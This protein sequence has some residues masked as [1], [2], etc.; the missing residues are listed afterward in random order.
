MEV[1]V[2]KPGRGRSRSWQLIRLIAGRELRS[3]WRTLTVLAVMASMWGAVT[4]TAVAGAR[5]TSSVV[6]RFRT[7]TAASDATFWIKHDLDGEALRRG[8]LARP[9]VRAAD[10]VWAA[11]TDLAWSRKTWVGLISGEG[12][13]W[14]VT[15]DRPLLLS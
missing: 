10:T 5:R 15:L 1:P 3:S 7:A 6:D 14:G 4:M 9:D 11:G 12:A 2:T 13:Q 8:L